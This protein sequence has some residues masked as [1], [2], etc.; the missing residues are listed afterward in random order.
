[1]QNS[2]NG[3]LVTSNRLRCGARRWAG[4]ALILLNVILSERGIASE[5]RITEIQKLY[6]YINKQVTHDT[7]NCV[8]YVTSGEG[9]KQ[10]KWSR[11]ESDPDF[12]NKG[13]YARATACILANTY[14]AKVTIEVVSEAGDWSDLREHYFYKT[15]KLAF[16]FER[17]LTVQAYDKKNNREIPGAP[18]VYERRVYFDEQGVLLKEIEKAFASEGMKE[19]PVDFIYPLEF[20]IYKS[21]DE[22][23]FK[24]NKSK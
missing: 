2:H 4:I 5:Q 16:F 23:P 11:V 9:Y 20:E 3:V 14:V 19:F 8:R 15:G 24:S 18:Y 1:M 21:A 10:R 12:N 6:S 17:Q 13:Y 7:R 22:L